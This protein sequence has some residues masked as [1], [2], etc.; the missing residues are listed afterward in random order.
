M[1]NTKHLSFPIVIEQDEDGIFIVSCPILQ[2]CHTYGKTVEE[3][4][5]NIRE[6]IELCL[7]DTS[8]YSTNLNQF[9]G[10]RQLDITIPAKAV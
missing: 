5:L 7:E 9:V 6:V 3:A 2:G 4:L 1:R 8:D 10:I